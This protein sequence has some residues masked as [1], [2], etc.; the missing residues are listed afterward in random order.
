MAVAGIDLGSRAIKLAIVEDGVLTQSRVV[1]TTFDPLGV[2][3]QLLAGRS[4]D[5]LVATGYGRH[6]FRE[7]WPAAEVITEIKAVAHG[8]RELVPAAR[9]I[10]DI[11][12]QDTKAIALDGRGRVVKFLMNDRCAAGT[13][14]FLE[15]MAVALSYTPDQFVEAA[16]RATRAEKLSSMC[17]VFAESEVVS[18]VARGRS[19]EEIAMGIHQAIA[20]RTLSLLQGVLSDF[21]GGIDFPEVVF[22]GGGAL[23]ACLHGLLSAGLGRDLRVPE[24]PQIAAALGC[25]LHGERA[26]DA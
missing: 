1:D 12:G 14:R 16:R 3:R 15:V 6:L 18:L 4:L 11:G 26:A 21:P 25:A 8:A 17:A 19:R 5:G 24:N 7:H 2:C 20:S 9:A 10:V 22:T 13:G 23:N